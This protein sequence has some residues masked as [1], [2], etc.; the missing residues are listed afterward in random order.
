[1]YGITVARTPAKIISIPES[2][3]FFSV[4]VVFQIPMIN[5]DKK[6]MIDAVIKL[7]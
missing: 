2:S 4:N 3:Q 6:V 7:V 5:R 1:M